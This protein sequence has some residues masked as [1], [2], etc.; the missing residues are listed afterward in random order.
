VGFG[1]ANGA[2]PEV[3]RWPGS[4]AGFGADGSGVDLEDVGEL[5]DGVGAGQGA[6]ESIARLLRSVSAPILGV[7]HVP[8]I[9][10]FRAPGRKMLEKDIEPCYGHDFCVLE[11]SRYSQGSRFSGVKGELSS[12][13]ERALGRFAIYYNS[14]TNEDGSGPKAA[15]IC[16]LSGPQCPNERVAHLDS[17]SKYRV[18]HYYCALPRVGGRAYSLESIALADR[19]SHRA[20]GS[21]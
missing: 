14:D 1:E 11:A 17:E 21:T 4:G 2:G 12:P 7:G 3:K 13:G 10:Q 6:R 5:G 9:P 20:E 16:W 15:P 19:H 18:G 8:K